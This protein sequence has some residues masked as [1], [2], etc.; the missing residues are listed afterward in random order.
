MLSS[1]S[2][3]RVRVLPVLLAVVEGGGRGRR[4]RWVFVRWL[5]EMRQ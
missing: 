1:Q 4:G 2:S 5:E 3:K